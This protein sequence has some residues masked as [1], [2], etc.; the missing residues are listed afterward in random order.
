MSHSISTTNVG[1]DGDDGVGRS[2]GHPVAKYYVTVS[3]SKHMVNKM[4]EYKTVFVLLALTEQD[5]AWDNNSTAKHN[6]KKREGNERGGSHSVDTH[7]TP[8]TTIA[9]SIGRRRER[10]RE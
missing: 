6:E 9:R 8:K 1:D 2:N 3:R 7:A 10:Q 4:R 5:T